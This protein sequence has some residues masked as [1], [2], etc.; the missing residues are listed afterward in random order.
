MRS[1]SKAQFFAAVGPLV[2][3]SGLIASHW[4]RLPDFTLGA[5]AG[6]GIG[7]GL[8]ALNLRRGRGA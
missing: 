3:A 7:L 2:M 4:F 6:V 1:G 8:L 5:V